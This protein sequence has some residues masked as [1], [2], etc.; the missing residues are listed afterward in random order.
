M[1]LAA[2]IS[3]HERTRRV[4]A[5]IRDRTAVHAVPLDDPGPLLEF[6]P[7]LTPR[8][9]APTHLADLAGAIERAAAGERVRACFSVPVRHGKTSLCQ[10]AIAWL[11]RKDPTRSILYVSYAHGFA[12]K[13]TAKA[14]EL[15]ARAGVVL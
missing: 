13:Q 12:K 5:K 8:F 7:Q 2:R 3:R 10:H 6:V 4:I 15:A 11:L 1:G 14:K 9:R